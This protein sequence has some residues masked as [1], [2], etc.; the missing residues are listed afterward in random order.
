MILV[1][2]LVL[3]LWLSWHT[4]HGADI[5]KGEFWAARRHALVADPFRSLLIVF[6]LCAALFF[7]ASIRTTVGS[8]PSP[9][10]AVLSVFFLSVGGAGLGRIFW[11]NR[12]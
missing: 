4:A 5:T 9:L 7:Y 11:A 3:I 12:H 2:F 8:Q 10:V 1:V 6:S